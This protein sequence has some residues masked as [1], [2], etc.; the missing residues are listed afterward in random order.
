MKK[1]LSILIC[2]SFIIGVKAQPKGIA[3]FEI[4][5]QTQKSVCFTSTIE[6]QNKSD[7]YP[8]Y[9][10]VWDFGDGSAKDTTKDLSKNIKHTYSK[11]GQ[12]WVIL[13]VID[14]TLKDVSKKDSVLATSKKSKIANVKIYRP[15]HDEFTYT[16]DE[17]ETF[18]VTFKAPESFKPFD[19]KAWIYRWDF[20][21]GTVQDFDTTEVFHHYKEENLKPGY[22]V[23]LTLLL[24]SDIVTL[25]NNKTDE[26]F[27]SI[28]VPVVIKD[29][30]FKNDSSS[31]NKIPFI[32]NVFTPN[33]DGKN[34]AIVLQMSDTTA[35]KAI[36]NNDIFFFKTNGEHIFT[37]WI[38]NRWGNLVYKSSG[39]SIVWR[40]ETS[41]GD[42][43]DSGVYYYVVESTAADERHKASGVI[44]LIRE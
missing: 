38:Y 25:S 15:V 40:G 22:S 5:N 44:Q 4:V 24:N 26:C 16:A 13:S 8:G 2:Y 7:D 42:E 31:N 18:N 11:D 14:T 33:K 23:K 3:Y 27:D 9:T 35:S 41:N 19:A 39:Q 17:F 12:Y 1:I 29:G 32:P 43:L 37:I 34:D 10:Y 21:D 6:F 28:T 36:K 20:G 30:F